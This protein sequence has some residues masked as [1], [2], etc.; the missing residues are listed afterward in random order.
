MTI[1]IHAK[2]TATTMA[3]DLSLPYKV[4]DMALADFGNKEMQAGGKRNA[5][6]DGGAGEVRSP[7]SPS[8]GLR[9]PAAST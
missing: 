3:L 1:V 2:A 7:T 9:L 4:A 5:G 8:K 6:P